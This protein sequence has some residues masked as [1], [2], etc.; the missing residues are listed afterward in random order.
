MTDDV[1]ERFAE[2]M[3]GSDTAMTVVTTTHAG[4]HAGCLVGFQSQCSI[5]PPRYAVWLS[6]ANHTYRVGVHARHF[7]IHQLTGDDRGLAELFGGRTGDQ[8]D[9]FAD[10]SW[11]PHP[12]GVRV[13]DT[14]G[15]WFVGRRIAMFDH[16]GDHV[17]VVLQP[18]EV[19]TSGDVDPLRL[20]DVVDIT[21]GHEAEERPVPAVER[22]QAP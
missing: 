12:T 4:E 19:E 20:S 18:V 9:K 2:L 3:A 1:E 21:P 10:C 16:G 7:A 11:R 8:T 13:L 5:E 17:C 14:C 22:A 6:K 15:H